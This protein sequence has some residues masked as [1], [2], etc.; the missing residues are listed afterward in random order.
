MIMEN[1]IK[2]LGLTGTVIGIEL[3]AVLIFTL[4]LVYFRNQQ[5]AAFIGCFSMLSMV[6]SLI[7]VFL[8]FEK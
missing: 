6:L 2:I 5:T 8:K 7:A 3:I 1:L 4:S